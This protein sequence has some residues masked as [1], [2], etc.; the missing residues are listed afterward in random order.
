MIFAAATLYA[1]GKTFFW[2]T[3]LGIVSEQTPKG[4]ALTLNSVSGIGMLAVGVL[5]FPYI[6]ALQEKKAVSEVAAVEQAA[7]AGLVQDGEAAAASLEDK[8]IYY[9]TIKYQT[10]TEDAST[11]IDGVPE[12]KTAKEGAAQKALF[13]MALFPFIMLIAFVGLFLYFKSKGGYKAQQLT[14][15]HADE[16][17]DDGAEAGGSA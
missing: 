2:P 13:N 11:K 8:S 9:G 7:T 17:I 4:G 10:W 3:M 14:D 15:G 12:L 1:L 6:G 16:T 5:G